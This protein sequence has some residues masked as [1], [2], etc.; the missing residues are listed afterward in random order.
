M[1]GEWAYYKSKFTPKQCKFILDHGLDLPG[2]EATLGV[3]GDSQITNDEYRKSKI[4]FIQKNNSTFAWLFDEMW[5]M[6][7]E[8]NGLW[9]DFHISKLDYIQ[10]AEYDASYKGEYK[11][12]HD[13]FYIN[14][15]PTYHRKI[16]AI[17]QLTDPAEYEGGQ[18]EMYEL[19]EYPD[20][21][22]LLP[23][24]TVI[25]FPAFVVHA[26]L[27]ITRGKRHSLAC[28]FDGP[29]WR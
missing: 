16:T 9:F 28:W 24:G 4:R 25:F 11:R 12:H 20:P 26:A 19:N 5:R 29:K 18:F 14:N 15:D 2:K 21:K 17:V 23:Q 27:P 13:V 6:A 1:K 3:A 7:I 22:E 8:T 10:L